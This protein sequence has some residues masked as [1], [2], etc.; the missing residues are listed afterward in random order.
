MKKVLIIATLLL[1]APALA[2]DTPCSKTGG[3]TF[4]CLATQGTATGGESVPQSL[5]LVRQSD[6]GQESCFNVAE[7]VQQA[8]NVTVA[9]GSS[10]VYN[11][12][13]FDGI[14]CTG[15]A[16]PLSADTASASNIVVPTPSIP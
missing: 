3:T 14:N 11:A 1:A 2:A 8:F 7:G 5:T 12:Q 4:Q 13:A 16:S 15:T 6:G 9:V 10:E